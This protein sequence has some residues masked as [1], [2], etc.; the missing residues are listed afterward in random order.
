MA[1]LCTASRAKRNITT[2]L[3]FSDHVL[4][5]IIDTLSDV[6][7]R[8]GHV[9]KSTMCLRTNAMCCK[10]LCCIIMMSAVIITYIIFTQYGGNIV[11]IF[12]HPQSNASAILGE[13]EHATF[14]IDLPDTMNGYVFTQKVAPSHNNT[15]VLDH[16]FILIWLHGA[17]YSSQTWIDLDILQHLARQSG[18][19]SY[20]LDIPG[21]GQSSDERFVDNEWLIYAMH[22]I[23]NAESENKFIL[24][25]ASMSG[26]YA[27]PLLFE[28]QHDLNDNNEYQIG[29]ITVAPVGTHLYTMEQ[30]QA[31]TIPICIIY[32]QNDVALGISSRNNLIQTPNN[33]EFVIP[34]GAHACYNTDPVLFV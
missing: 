15:Q 10:L 2:Y 3:A 6:H 18:Y 34:E 21:Y 16:G 5:Q 12:S 28:N 13:I 17:A 22:Q 4:F 9:F 32:G 31:V 7:V 30:Y 1:P 25:T 24:I 23:L 33:T 11:S 14:T 8:S 19:I 29:L 27:M 20:A 26:T